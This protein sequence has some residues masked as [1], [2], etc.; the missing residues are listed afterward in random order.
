M[1]YEFVYFDNLKEANIY[2]VWNMSTECMNH[3]D[4]SKCNIDAS[5]VTWEQMLQ[6]SQY[7]YASSKQNFVKTIIMLQ[8]LV[9]YAS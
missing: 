3:Y 8:T 7:L 2:D 6:V 1:K 4:F 9:H 5:L